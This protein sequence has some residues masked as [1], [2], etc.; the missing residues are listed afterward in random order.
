M[1]A[2]GD[3][4]K[5]EWIRHYL[6]VFLPFAVVLAVGVMAHYY[7]IHQTERVTREA[8][9]LLNIG[10]AR[11]VLNSDLSSVVT[12]LLFLARFLETQGFDASGHLHKQAIQQ[13]FYTF[14]R[15]KRL[16]DQIR[17]LA[18]D[19][20]EQI[21]INYLDGAPHQVAE[22]RLQDK[23]SRY[24]F[25][26]A[27]QLQPGEIY[28]SPLDLNIEQGV[29]EQP[30]KP[31][32]RF[33]LP[34]FDPKQQ[35]RGILVLNYLGDRLLGNFARAGAN[36]ADHIHLLNAAGYW[37]SSPNKADEWGFMREHGRAFFDLYPEAWSRIEQ[38]I[39]GQF[40]T[41]AGLFS[42]ETVTPWM[43]ASQTMDIHQ[44]HGA[45]IP[46]TAARWK[47]VARVAPDQDAPGLA[48]FLWQ[49]LP[50]YL[51]ISALLLIGSGLLTL[52]NIRHRRAQRQ[53]EY[54]RRF[55]QTFEDMQL[56][57]ISV[58]RDYRLVFCNDYFL[59]LTGWRLQEIIGCD[60][61]QRF[62]AG[63]QKAAVREAFSR[64]QSETN[65]PR[66]VE[67]AILLRSG[68]R[69]LIAWH[70]TPSLD[71]QGQVVGITT[72][73]EDVTERKRAEEKVKK[74]SRAV[75]QSPSIVL[76]TD[77]FGLIEYVNPKFTEV[78]G[79][80][81]EEVL[82]RK[83]NI[84]K[85]GETPAAVYAQLWDTVVSGA[86]WRGE[87]H[88]RRK[89]G[90]LYWESAS[91]SALR[92][93]AG[94]ISNFVA[95]KEDITER[96]R[97]ES[98]VEKRNRELART[99]ALTAMGRMASMIAHD[100]RNP[101]SSVKMGIQ[102]L[103]KQAS[104]D[105]KELVEIGLDQIHYMEEI[106]TDML[107]Y[108]RPEAVKT[109]WVNVAKVLDVTLGSLQR[110][111][112]Q[113]AVAIETE[114]QPGLP[115]LPGD[116]SKLRQLFSNL[117]VNALQSLAGQTPDQPM[118]VIKAGYQMTESGA[119]IEVSICDNGAGLSS[120]DPEILFEPFYTTRS[121]GTGLGLAIARQIAGQHNGK[122]NL[123]A[124]AEGGACAQ[125][126]L[127]TAPSEQDLGRTTVRHDIA[128]V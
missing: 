121:K 106:L 66:Q 112:D 93:H 94:E 125:V 120:L 73:G 127:P 31:M 115:M 101:L 30:L 32:M 60:W 102:I 117:I 24:Y 48:T 85:S 3:S 80:T 78:T 18:P 92:N 113:A 44:P 8:D 27:M 43:V 46:A 1:K 49:H 28:I 114:Y 15:E 126:I 52:A 122:V 35:K 4:N 97:L 40:R 109:E 45:P 104:H 62:V 37:L 20:R 83:T 124:G 38:E 21:R 65:F 119:A 16:Y 108:A 47:V 110:R 29:I 79:Y 5:F 71:A 91:I 107:S 76:L 17:F 6:S 88:N 123:A 111:I 2:P 105:H 69:R 55:R 72:V 77:R 10:L 53:T 74:L 87:F 23:S 14:A 34:L 118:I 95:V 26:A 36:I 9:E 67:A 50:L 39:S 19:G 13:L 64:M 70:N 98:E 82:G 54:E 41:R 90:E 128:G 116:G 99:E 56:A 42:F 61:I 75:E 22:T 33:A 57:T 11:S 103:G 7:T 59:R 51:T 58:D 25:A 63:E 68:E 81:A 84:L 86:E 100:L 89:N 96:K 12:D